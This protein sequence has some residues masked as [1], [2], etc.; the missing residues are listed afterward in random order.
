MSN[1]KISPRVRAALFLRKKKDSELV[2]Y[3]N[4]IVAAMNGNPRFLSPSPALSVVQSAADA[5]KQTLR[6]AANNGDLE[7][8]KVTVSRY[9]LETLIV[10]LSL[11]VCRVANSD[12]VTAT[13]TVVSAGMAVR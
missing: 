8:E 7:K 1:F 5:F 9:K 10:A 4:A 2:T 12:V 11:Y 3:A 13:T 6:D